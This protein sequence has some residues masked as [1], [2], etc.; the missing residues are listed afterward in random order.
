MELTATHVLCV[1]Q[2]KWLV[3]ILFK[4]IKG[5]LGLGESQ[6]AK[7][8]ARIGKSIGITIIAYPVL[9]PA[10]KT[11]I[12]PGRPWSIF[13]LKNDFTT[14]VICNQLQHNMR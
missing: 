2:R 4:E 10:R 1:Y 5:G 12:R 11:D 9:I 3:K 14:D 6:V 13:H 8:V 7:E